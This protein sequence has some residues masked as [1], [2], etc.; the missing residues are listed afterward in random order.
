MV[1]VLD[2]ST[3]ISLFHAK[4]VLPTST[5]I[6]DAVHQIADK[7]DPQAADRTLVHGK[8]G[9]GLAHASWIKFDTGIGDDEP[10][11]GVVCLNGHCYISIG[12]LQPI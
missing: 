8:G 1:F 10:D 6:V 4:D 5:L 9:V 12:T 2:K 3:R 11:Y 7:E